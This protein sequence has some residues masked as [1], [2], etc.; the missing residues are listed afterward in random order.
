MTAT[1]DVNS[2]VGRLASESRER[3]AVLK[4][5]GIDPSWFA[6]GLRPLEEVCRERGLDPQDVLRDLLHCGAADACGCGRDWNTA[7]LTDLAEHIIAVHHGFL[8]REIPRLERM[9]ENV[10][11]AHGGEHPSLQPT[12]RAFARW[13]AAIEGH[14]NEEERMLFPIVRLLEGA[15]RCVKCGT[16]GAPFADWALDA[17][18]SQHDR[19]DSM[20]AELKESAGG[21]VPPENACPAHRRLLEGL[22]GVEADMVRHER[23]EH[24]ILFRLARMLGARDYGAVDEV[25]P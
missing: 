23:E 18:E 21:F 19:C 11:E 2:S 16:V 7:T 14:M 15:D 20:F 9:L 24:D 25:K 8:R 1:P 5:K 12:G 17:S 6:Q 3:A 22:A 13:R 4:S 10:S